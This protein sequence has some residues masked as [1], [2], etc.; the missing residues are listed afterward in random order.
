[1]VLLTYCQCPTEGVKSCRIND[2]SEKTNAF[3]CLTDKTVTFANT[4]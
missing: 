3:D 2:V 4:E 1:L